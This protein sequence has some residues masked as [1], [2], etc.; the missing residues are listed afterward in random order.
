MAVNPDFV[1]RTYPPSE[2]Y[3]VGREKIKEF[4]EAIGDSNPA[5]RDVQAAKALGHP[6]LVAP[7]TFAIIISQQV[8]RQAIFDPELGLDYSRVVHGEQRFEYTRPIHAGDALTG[9]L[10]VTG[11]RAAGSNELVTTKCELQTTEGE[12]VCT[13]YSTVVSRDTAP[14]QREDR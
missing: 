14:D 9:T 6:D 10:T 5:Y 8:G 2:P 3:E 12:L 4:A 13:A 1:G 7:P 11:V